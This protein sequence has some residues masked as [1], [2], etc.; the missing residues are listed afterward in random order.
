MATA[1]P[2]T[3]RPPRIWPWCAWHRTCSKKRQQG[4]PSHA[5][6]RGKNSHPNPCLSTGEAVLGSLPTCL[7]LNRTASGRQH[8]PLFHKWPALPRLRLPAATPAIYAPFLPHLASALKRGHNMLWGPLDKRARRAHSS[9]PAR[10]SGQTAGTS[11]L[12]AGRH[13]HRAGENAWNAPIHTEIRSRTRIG[14]MPCGAAA[15]RNICR[16][17]LLRTPPLSVSGSSTSRSPHPNLRPNWACRSR[18]T[19]PA[20][21][22]IRSTRS[23]G[24]CAPPSSATNAARSCSSSA[25]S[26]SRRSWSQQATNI[27]VSKYFRGQIGTPERERSVKQLIG[28]VVDTITEWARTQKYFATDEDLQAFSDDLKHILVYQKAAFNSPVWFNCGFEKAPQCSACFIN[29]VAGHDGL[30]PDAGA[31]RRHAVQV[32]VGHGHEPVADPLVEGAARRRRHGVGAGVVHEG[33]RRVCRRHQVGRQDAPRGEDGHPQRRSSGHRR[34]HQLQGRGREEGLGAHRRRL[35]RLV[36]RAGLR[37]GVLPELEQQRAR[38]RRVHAR[39]ARRRRVGD[40][41]G[42]RRAR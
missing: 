11:Q 23:N 10:G 40:A 5:L 41:R 1:F 35:R 32:R 2:K 29:S 37:V 39:G 9:A 15:W 8:V 12:P 33:L 31:D 16:L 3:A 27:V 13:R 34:V 4:S 14:A 19:S 7:L 22:W 20:P 21:A 25:T 30:D 26:R 42:R 6:P 18:V 17:A 28:R 24:S 38:H 36:H